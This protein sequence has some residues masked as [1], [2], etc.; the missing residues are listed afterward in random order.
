MIIN[1]NRRRRLLE[2]EEPTDW[3]T[4]RGKHYPLNAE[5]DIVGGDP[6]TFGGEIPKKKKDPKKRKA[7]STEEVSTK[8]DK[9]SSIS[10]SFFKRK[11]RNS[12]TSTSKDSD[13]NVVGV[14][15]NSGR[16]SGGLDEF[17]SAIKSFEKENKDYRQIGSK[18][19]SNSMGQSSTAVYEN[20]DTGEVIEFRRSSFQAPGEK[21]NGV[22]AVNSYL[23]RDA[24][25]SHN[26]R[27]PIDLD[28]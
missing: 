26:F 5:G 20:P 13:G 4:V 16:A 18:Q 25:K 23:N 7:Y 2:D 19:D 14:S 21:A 11:P 3:I 9:L 6:R 8:S 10:K 12:Y 17:N 24:Y 15:W 27:S 1:E 22:T 28:R